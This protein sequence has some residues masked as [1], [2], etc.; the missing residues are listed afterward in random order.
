MRIKY[1]KDINGHPHGVVVQ[2]DGNFGWSYCSKWDIFNK[3]L[4]KII[5]VGRL[6]KST[7]AKVP[8]DIQRL[9]NWMKDYK[10]TDRIK[11]IT[12][13]SI[14]IDYDDDY[15][16]KGGEVLDTDIVETINSSDAVKD[17]QIDETEDI[18]FGSYD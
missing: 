2:E 11:K 16:S 6:H 7:K 15:F 1:L 9:I 8:Y 5:A 14:K 17:I 4:G 18:M 10:P 12:H 3:R 13:E